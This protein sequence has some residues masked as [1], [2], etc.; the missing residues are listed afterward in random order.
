MRTKTA[1]KANNDMMRRAGRLLKK[2][3]DVVL[4]LFRA[5]AFYVM[6][7]FLCIP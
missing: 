6:R 1:L 4:V 3:K 5:L 7:V 2:R